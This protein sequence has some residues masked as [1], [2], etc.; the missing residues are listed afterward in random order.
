M[1]VAPMIPKEPVR[2]EMPPTT[3]P[4]ATASLDGKSP[5]IAAPQSGLDKTTW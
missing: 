5:A 4:L 2:G 1:T 3:G